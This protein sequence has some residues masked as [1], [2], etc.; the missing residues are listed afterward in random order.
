MAERNQQ[1]DTF[2][3]WVNKA[4]SWLTR[5]EDYNDTEHGDEKGWRGRHFKAICFDSKGRLCYQGS[6]FMRAR[7]EDTFPVR[8]LWPDQV[9]LLMV[10]PTQEMGF[11]AMKTWDRRMKEGERNWVAMFKEVFKIMRETALKDEKP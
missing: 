3:E 7:D 10:E 1:F 9:P 2:Q 11:A 4:S 6:D 5:H 8:W